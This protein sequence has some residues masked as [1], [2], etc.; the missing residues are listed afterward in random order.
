MPPDI[1]LQMFLP[2]DDQLRVWDL[3]DELKPTVR[4]DEMMHQDHATAFT[5][6]KVARLDILRSIRASLDRAM[7]EGRTF[8]AW[9]ADLVPELKKIGW[10][11]LVTDA[12]ITGTH[13]PVIVNE[14]RLQ[15]IFR[16][17]IR[18]SQAAGRWAK[19]QREKHI[20]P[21]LRYISDHFRK[22][23]RLDH[24][25]WHGVI[26]PVDHPWWQ[27]HFPPNGWGCGC[28]YQQ[29]SQD[30][31]DARGW[32]VSDPPDDGPAT[33]FYAAARTKPIMVPPG[34][35][36]G[37]GYNPGTAH[38]RAVADKAMASIER[39]AD[40]GL[41]GPARQTVRDIVADPAFDQFLALPDG[42]FPVAVLDDAERLRI[43]AKSPLVV[44]PT[45]VYR[46]QLGEMPEIS[47]GHPELSVDD[48]RQLPYLI[49]RAL[50]IAQ[51]GDSKLIYFS[52]GS[53][54]YKVVVRQDD[55]KDLPAIVSFHGSQLRK[56][57]GELR[58]LKVIYDAR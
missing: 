44:L 29:L 6:A 21:F 33:P 24:R 41:I 10:W 53:R 16:T 57:K 25:S 32:T 22:D 17:N 20:A 15:T 47:R 38:L 42:A 13:K 2:A 14:R 46:K 45:N 19:I 35:S 26:L 39:A 48:Y 11:G 58:R 28:R 36:P 55:D 52:S 7:R 54:L 5:V 3:R 31:M 51:D 50:V 12:D 27:T 43:Q 9:K 8:E 23:P 37:F 4:W 56:L 49:E 30:M 18:M 34:I 1:R 40:A